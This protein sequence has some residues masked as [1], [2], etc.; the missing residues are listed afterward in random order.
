MNISATVN[1]H[2]ESWLVYRQRLR[3]VAF[4]PF[5]PRNEHVYLADGIA[6]RFSSKV[7]VSSA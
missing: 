3:F 1:G 4:V 5:L 2:R 6:P 7:R